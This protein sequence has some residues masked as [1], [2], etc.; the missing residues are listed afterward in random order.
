VQLDSNTDISL[1]VDY[2]SS[3]IVAKTG[4]SAEQG[5]GTDVSVQKGFR[6]ASVPELASKTHVGMRIPSVKVL[7]Q[8][9][10]RPSHFQELLPSNGSWRVVIFPGD[11]R[12]PRQKQRLAKIGSQLASPDSFLKRF[13]PA[14]ARYDS[15]IELL[16]VHAAPRKSVEFFDFPEVFRPY[17]EVD[18]WDYWKIFVDDESYHEGFGKIYEYLG[19]DPQE[20][21]A[22][23]IRPD[24]YVSYVGRMDAYDEMDRFFSAFMVPQRQAAKVAPVN[25]VASEVKATNAA[26]IAVAV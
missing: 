22:M 19:I 14:D 9:D 3:V 26:A 24:Q 23:I 15:V 8:A 17:H 12:E 1:A 10:A 20:G 4:D 6:V 7:N 16:S 13:T 21:C 11:I 25:D 5:D 18:G 2:G